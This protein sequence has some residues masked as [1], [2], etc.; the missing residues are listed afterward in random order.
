MLRKTRHSHSHRGQ[1]ITEY[2]IILALVAVCV[3][4][5][6]SLTGQSVAEVLCSVVDGLNLGDRNSCT[7]FL[8]DTFG[9][10]NNWERIWGGDNHTLNDGKLCMKGDERLLNKQPLPDDYKVSM[11][12][13]QLSSGNGYGIMF[14]MNQSGTNYAG[15]TFQ[16][17]PGLGK[18]FA[19]RR[20][21]RN[22]AELS[23]PLSMASAPANFNWS[24]PHKVDVVV[25]G[26]KFAA[27][28]DGVLVLTASDST[29]PSGQVGLRT[30]DSTD[31]CFDDLSVTAP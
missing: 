26:D 19:F 4:L 10:L 14:R 27:Y 7:N 9:N 13:A 6:L 22:G 12:Y 17:D 18:R 15:Y 24:A 29:Y 3:L 5:L 23:T 25:K 16:I 30:W 21:D 31:A 28:I 8:N 11:N 2:A 20:Y 1:S